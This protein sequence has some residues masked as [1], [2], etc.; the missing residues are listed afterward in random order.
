M[1]LRKYSRGEEQ[2]EIEKDPSLAPKERDA[3]ANMEQGSGR[4]HRE[5]VM[6]WACH[7]GVSEMMLAFWH[8]HEKIFWRAQRQSCF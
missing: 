6:A 8:E 5:S 7:G 1:K 3:A 2:Q 4:E